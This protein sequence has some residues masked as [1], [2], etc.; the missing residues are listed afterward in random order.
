MALRILVAGDHNGVRKTLKAT[1]EAPSDW[2]VCALVGDG[3]EA[4][5][6]M[7]ETKPDVLILD[8]AMPVMDGIHAAR[9]ILLAWPTLPVLLYTNRVSPTLERPANRAGVRQ[10][11]SKTAVTELL[12]AIEALAKGKPR[13]AARRQKRERAASEMGETRRRKRKHLSRDCV[14]GIEQIPS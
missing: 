7:R 12:S 11:L 14:E 8:F 5:Q 9:E 3:R 10:V 13:L 6:K 1:L 2:Q 4:V